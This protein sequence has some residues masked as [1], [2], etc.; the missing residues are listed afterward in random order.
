MSPETASRLFRDIARRD[1]FFKFARKLWTQ[2]IET[3]IPFE[4]VPD[5]Y[6]SL[7]PRDKEQLLGDTRIS[8]EVLEE[9]RLYLLEQKLEF[10]EQEF[11]ESIIAGVE[12]Y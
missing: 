8:P 6:T 2:E 11:E 3:G 12:S 7:P 1:L 9:F 5:D 10:K 4:K